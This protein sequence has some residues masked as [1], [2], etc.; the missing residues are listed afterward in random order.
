MTIL[1]VA[2][3]S[4]RHLMFKN[5]REGCCFDNNYRASRINKV[6]GIGNSCRIDQ[7]EKPLIM[8]KND[9]KNYFCVFWGI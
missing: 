7:R 9:A 3:F 2:L 5:N 8:M 4:E 1:F 6:G